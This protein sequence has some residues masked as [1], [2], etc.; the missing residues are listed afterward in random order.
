[1]GKLVTNYFIP[2]SEL[3]KERLEIYNISQKKLAKR[4][5]MSE[6][7]ISELLN[8]NVPLTKEIAIALEKVINIRSDVLMNYEIKYRWYI[9]RFQST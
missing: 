6:S 1:M 5:N 9:Q 8:N 2:T 3:I 7:H 4:L